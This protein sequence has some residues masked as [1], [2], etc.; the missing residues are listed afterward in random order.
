MFREKPLDPARNSD[1]PLNAEIRHAAVGTE[2]MPNIKLV[3]NK[4]YPPQPPTN[5]SDPVGVR[6]FRAND[7][8]ALVERMIFSQQYWCIAG[9]VP[10]NFG[11]LRGEN[12]S[13]VS[14]LA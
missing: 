9:E 10:A 8:I 11:K 6:S 12:I 1:Y 4:Q 14:R 5:L 13:V 2:T 7:D 3:L